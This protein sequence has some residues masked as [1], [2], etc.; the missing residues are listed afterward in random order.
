M[1]TVDGAGERAWRFFARDRDLDCR[2]PEFDA[3]TR[4]R[5]GDSRIRIR[6]RALPRD[7]VAEVDRL[8]PAAIA[9][10]APGTPPPGEE[11]TFVITDGARLDPSAV[12]TEPVLRCVDDV[13][14]TS[15]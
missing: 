5:G 11:H 6:A 13:L 15:G 7:P 12:L 2:E 10:T 8:D 14:A 3:Q 4:V 1:P 9:D